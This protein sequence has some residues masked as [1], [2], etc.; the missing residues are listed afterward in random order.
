[1]CEICERPDGLATEAEIEAA[2]D[3]ER[4]ASDIL[5]TEIAALCMMAVLSGMPPDQALA[6][7]HLRF[8]KWQELPEVRAAGI[9]AENF[10]SQRRRPD[11]LH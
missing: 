7:L 3:W 11:R 10:G 5:K 2:R 1:M 8:I 6:R 9:T 4:R